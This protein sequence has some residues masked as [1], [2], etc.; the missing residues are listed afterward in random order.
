MKTLAIALAL[1]SV[2]AST[3]AHATPPCHLTPLAA[4]EEWLEIG[5]PTSEGSPA[6]H[7]ASCVD[8]CKEWLKQCKKIAKVSAKCYA[9]SIGLQTRI[10]VAQCKTRE[11]KIDRASCVAEAKARD[12]ALKTDVQTRFA[13]ALAFCDQHLDD[14]VTFC[15]TES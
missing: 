9:T 6:N 4:A 7:L 14:C 10:E 11:D 15:L 12:F 2:C 8:V 1:M 3:A 5:F 13:G